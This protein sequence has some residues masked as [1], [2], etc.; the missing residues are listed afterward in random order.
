MNPLRR[1][2]NHDRD[3]Q[4]SEE[5]DGKATGTPSISEGVLAFRQCGETAVHAA[6]GVAGA[7]L[8]DAAC[9][10]VEAVLLGMQRHLPDVHMNVKLV[11]GKPGGSEVVSLAVNFH[12]GPL[13]GE[14]AT[15]TRIAVGLRV[16]KELRFAIQRPQ[17]DVSRSPLVL[18]ISGLDFPRLP[19][20]V[21]LREMLE[22][23][24]KDRWSPD[25]V[26]RWWKEHKDLEFPLPRSKFHRLVES[27]LGMRSMQFLP[28]AIHADIF[29]GYLHTSDLCIEAFEFHRDKKGGVT[30]TVQQKQAL[31]SEE[32][33]ARAMNA[34]IARKMLS[35]K[36][37]SG[38]KLCPSAMNVAAMLYG[39]EV[40]QPGAC[41]DAIVKL[42][43]AA[44]WWGH[45]SEGWQQFDETWLCTDK[46]DG[47]GRVVE[48]QGRIIWR[49]AGD[50]RAPPLPSSSP[51]VD[52]SS[53]KASTAR[54]LGFC[55]FALLVFAM[56]LLF[57]LAR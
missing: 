43:S 18:R 3:P 31:T 29:W 30:V 57:W 6:A 40:N 27:F 5:S 51:V 21:R 17:P 38:E 19:D 8:V 46:K 42:L 36:R 20:V 12:D 39:P 47:F 33:Q 41:L 26:F 54:L 9:Q 13:V 10:L 14:I 16:A 52:P 56:R 23:A 32:A 34:D 22:D 49:V 55:R 4:Q 53:S 7:P 11:H 37:A 50:K 44:Q 35:E 45:G 48:K 1:F 15:R 28:P 25:S 24:L 2:F